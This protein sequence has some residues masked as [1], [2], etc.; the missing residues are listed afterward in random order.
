MLAQYSVDA[1]GAV[2]VKFADFPVMP[3]RGFVPE[4][5]ATGVVSEAQLGFVP[6]N[7]VTE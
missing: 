5:T 6:L 7:S 2:K 3:V 1:V 4:R